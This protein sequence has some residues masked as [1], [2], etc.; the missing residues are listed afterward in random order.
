MTVIYS[1]PEAE[2]DI[3]EEVLSP[4]EFA[5]KIWEIVGVAL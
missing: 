5:D 2:V 4:E 1:E 3:E